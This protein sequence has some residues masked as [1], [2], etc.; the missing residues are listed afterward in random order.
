MQTRNVARC[1]KP[2]RA[3]L[4]FLPSHFFFDPKRLRFFVSSFS[5]SNSSLLTVGGCGS[6]FPGSN[7]SAIVSCPG[8]STARISLTLASSLSPCVLSF[9]IFLRP[10]SNFLFRVSISI[11]SSSGL[12]KS[13]YSRLVLTLFRAFFT[14]NP[15]AAMPNNPLTT[16][17]DATVPVA[18][19]PQGS[20]PSSPS[21]SP[22]LPPSL[23]QIKSE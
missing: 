5:S 6:F 18:A 17:P 22:L 14:I 16:A 15:A 23:L 12:S 21:P 7:L 2:A 3:D 10:R 1:F 9:A 13:N 19:S 20:P 11:G 8:P 4:K